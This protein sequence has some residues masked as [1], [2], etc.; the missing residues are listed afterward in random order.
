AGESR[1]FAPTEYTAGSAFST[2]SAPKPREAQVTNNTLITLSLSIISP[3]VVATPGARGRATL[4]G[5]CHAVRQC[6]R[7][8]AA[9]VPQIPQ[10]RSL[11]WPRPT[12]RKL[13]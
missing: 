5:R 3:G 1:A 4:C 10:G 6:P 12:N 9:S 11:R 13:L 2:I 7:L 8:A